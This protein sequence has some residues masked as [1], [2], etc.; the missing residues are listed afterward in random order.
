MLRYGVDNASP[1]LRLVNA[2]R[3]VDLIAPV[4]SA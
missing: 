4:K 3:G 1:G 2:G